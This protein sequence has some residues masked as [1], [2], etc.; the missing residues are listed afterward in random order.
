MKNKKLGWDSYS[1]LG[2]TWVGFRI[3]Y[4]FVKDTQID[5]DN[6]KTAQTAH[7]HE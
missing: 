3:S 7:L 6:K 2:C 5:T 4:T 1:E